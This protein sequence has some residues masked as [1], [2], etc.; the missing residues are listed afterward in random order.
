[1]ALEI[2]TSA[3]VT[4]DLKLPPTWEPSAASFVA[5]RRSIQSDD[6][7]WPPSEADDATL[8]PPR[9]RPRARRAV[10]GVAASLVLFGCVRLGIDGGSG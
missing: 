6:W 7:T 4:Q 5:V 10:L 8:L 2:S 9:G 1:M 3:N